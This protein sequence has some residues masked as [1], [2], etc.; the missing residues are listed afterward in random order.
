MPR[1]RD[2]AVVATFTGMIVGS[3]FAL[4]GVTNVK[5]LDTLVF[6]S[7]YLFGL[8]V[9]LAAGVISETIWSFASPIGPAGPIAPF[10]IAGEGIFAFA[11]WGARRIWGVDSV[12]VTANSLFFGGMMAICAFLWDLETNTAT[13]YI[14]YWPSLNFALWLNTSFG[15]FTMPFNVAHEVSDFAFGVLLV[16]ALIALIPRISGGRFR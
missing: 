13:A 2:V 6:T 12:P 5:L 14:A 4:S 7:A 3:D 9:G 10:L 11:G 8:R 15:F 16:P 1:T